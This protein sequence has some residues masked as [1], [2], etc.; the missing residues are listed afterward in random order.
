VQSVSRPPVR[1][2]ARPPDASPARRTPG[3]AG[4]RAA[5]ERRYQDAAGWA[6]RSRSATALRPPGGPPSA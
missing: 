1:R 4:R 5:A 2:P 6:R 3:Q